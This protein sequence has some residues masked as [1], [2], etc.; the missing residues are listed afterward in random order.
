MEQNSFMKKEI[1]GKVKTAAGIV[2]YNPE[3]ERLQENLMAASKQVDFVLIY[4]NAS[5]NID[6]IEQVASVFQNVQVIKSDTNKGVAGALNE[7]S[8]IAIKENVEWFLALDH[9]SVIPDNFIETCKSFIADDIGII[10][11]VMYDKR[12]PQIDATNKD[13]TA[14]VDF[15][16]TSGSFVNLSVW[17]QLGKYDEFLFVGLVD[18]EYCKRVILNGYKILRLNEMLMDHELGTLQPARLANIYKKLA[19]ILH[20]KTIAALSYRR[21]VS[22]FR[23]YY[24]TRNI[25]YLSKKYENYPCYEF[26]KKFAIKNGISDFIRSGFCLKVLK[27]VVKGFSEGIK[28]DVTDDIRCILTGEH[29]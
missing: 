15:C 28:I 23:A 12:R 17:E 1:S 14:Y 6:E 4:D 25:V 18:N 29:K 10:C 24:A 2:T 11:P 22:P 7:L 26:S 3:I 16:I 27:A 19:V 9:D 8:D 13:K 5:K 21:K 20:S